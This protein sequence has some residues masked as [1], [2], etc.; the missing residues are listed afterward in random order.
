MIKSWDNIEDFYRT[1]S[2]T[3]ADLKSMLSMVEG[4]MLSRYRDGLFPWTSMWN[5]CLAQ[6]P[7]SYPYDGPYLLISPLFDGSIQFIYIDTPQKAKQWQRV[8]PENE[9][10][11]RLENFFDQLHWF[12]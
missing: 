10:F 8:M 4:I 12:G 11:A 1:G 2:Q 6:H 7:V 5:L 9:A 3:R